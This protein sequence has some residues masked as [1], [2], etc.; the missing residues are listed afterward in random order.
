MVEVLVA[1]GHRSEGGH[2]DDDAAGV[3]RILVPLLGLGDLAD[4]LEAVEHGDPALPGQLDLGGHAGGRAVEA[5]GPQL[6]AHEHQLA[7]D[8]QAQLALGRDGVVH[9]LREVD[10][11]GNRDAAALHGGPAELLGPLDVVLVVPAAGGADVNLFHVVVSSYLWRQL[12]P[13]R[14]IALHISMS[15]SM[16]ARAVMS[17]RVSRGVMRPIRASVS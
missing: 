11:R 17:S 15:R 5:E 8:A 2:S 10:V 14:V 6:V 9:E 1:A 16:V 12:W 13:V 4:G 7:A 3:L